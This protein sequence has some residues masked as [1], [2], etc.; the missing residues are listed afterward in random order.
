VNKALAVARKELRQILR[1]ARTLVILLFVPVFFLLL[2]GYA[3][4]WDIRHIRLAVIDRDHSADSRTLISSFTNSTFFDKVADPISMAEAEQLIDNGEV[5]AVLVI[6]EGM[7]RAVRTGQVTTVQVIVN[8][9]NATTATTVVGYAQA[10]VRGV[11][12]G[13]RLEI[14]G[15]RGAAPPISAEPRIWFNPELKSTLFLVPGLIGFIVMI[16]CVISTS[17][18]IVREK[19]RGTW[20]QVRMAPIDTVSYVVG[21]TIP[22]FVISYASA[23]FIIFAAMWLFDMPMRGSWP[24]LLA[25]LSL[26]VVG[27]LGTGLLVS[28]VVD[29][30][31]LAFLVSLILSLLPT[32]ILS[33]FIFPIASMP[34]AIQAISFIVPAR[35]FL[36]IL[37]GIVLKGTEIQVFGPQFA[38]LA[39]YGVIVLG[40]ASLRL[41]K[42]RG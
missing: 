40:L 31:A 35:Y 24:A 33:G 38:A 4:N 21:K 25:A 29:S 20:E 32:M 6:P 30:Q 28:T 7:S 1:D 5:R 15:A 12:A 10:I 34:V 9:D 16:S 8:G 42:E 39:I 13:I 23:L 3:L 2:Y 22:Y 14:A 11:S 18:S 37:R 36:V 27:A 19:E 41:A 26:Y 17:L